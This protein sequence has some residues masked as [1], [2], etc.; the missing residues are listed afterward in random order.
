MKLGPVLG[1]AVLKGGQAYGPGAQGSLSVLLDL[2]LVVAD[3][4]RLGLMHED[5]GL[6]PQVPQV[7]G[8][9]PWSGDQVVQFHFR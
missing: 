7:A 1:E 5:V 6:W 9:G 3:E 8:P 4:G 2:V